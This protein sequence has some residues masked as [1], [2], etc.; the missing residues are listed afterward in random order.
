[1][2]VNDFPTADQ[3]QLNGL[4]QDV[5]QLYTPGMVKSAVGS[6]RNKANI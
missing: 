6:S 4:P 2:Q 5:R 1:M 3:A